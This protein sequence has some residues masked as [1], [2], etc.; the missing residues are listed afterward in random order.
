MSVAE[1]RRPDTL[2]VVLDAER[3]VTIPESVS[4]EL[5]LRAGDR[6]AVT[7]DEQGGVVLTSRR[8]S[9]RR[10]LERIRRDLAASGIT[11]EELQEEGRRVREELTRELYGEP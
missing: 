6:L 3:R 1:E 4:D 11:E 7:V 9:A 2:E 5:G 10:A 8:A